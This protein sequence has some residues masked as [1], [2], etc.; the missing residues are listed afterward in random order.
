MLLL[1]CALA[2]VGCASAEGRG[3]ARPV[4]VSVSVLSTSPV[5]VRGA[6]F[7]PRERIVVNV[8]A[9]VH[10]RKQTTATAGGAFRLVFGRLKPN[11]CAGI[12]ISAVGTRGSRAEYR[13]SPG[14][15]SQP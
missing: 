14:V 13:R 8:V 7:K 12:S 6:G 10:L 5:A 3:E 9:G 11:A 1:F 4:R 2:A 15:C